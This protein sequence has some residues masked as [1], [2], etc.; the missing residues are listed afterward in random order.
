MVAPIVNARNQTHRRRPVVSGHAVALVWVMV[1]AVA[2]IGTATAQSDVQVQ[3]STDRTEVGAE[4]VI[5]YKITVSGVSPSAVETPEPPPTTNLVLKDPTPVATRDL[6]FKSG[7][8]GRSISFEWRYQPMRVGIARLRE[9]DVV[10]NGEA[11]T[12]SEIRVRIVPQSQAPAASMGAQRPSRSD[13]SVDPSAISSLKPDDL[14]IRVTSSTDRVYQNEQATVE[15]RLFFRPGVQLRHSRLA[16]AWDANGFWREELDVASRPIP[17][18]DRVNGETYRTIMLKRVAVF[19]TRTGTLQVDP[20]QIETEAYSADRV[21]ARTRF[22]SQSQYEPI[23]L[24]SSSISLNVNA[25]PAGAPPAFSGAVGQ[26]SLDANVRSDSAHVGG[27]V[28]LDVTVRGSGNIATLQPPEVEVPAAF[29]MYDPKVNT[30]LDR[31]GT[32]IRGKKTFTYIL[33]PGE[34]GRYTL[35]PVSFAYFDPEA[36]QFEVLKTDP[37]R[38]DVTGDA[39]PAALGTTGAGLPVGDIAGLMASP[40]LEEKAPL[41]LHRRAWPYAAIVIPLLIAAGLIVVRRPTAPSAPPALETANARLEE[42]R[43]RMR[44]DEDA[45]IYALLERAV[46]GFVSDRTGVSVA[47]FS[48]DRLDRFL[49]RAG[50]DREHRNGLRELLDACDQA[51]FAPS[52][53]Q[54]DAMQIAHRRA[55]TLIRHFDERL[56]DT[57]P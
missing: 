49:E 42:A 44:Q 5:T 50:A 33:V 4:D 10:I 15:Y 34:N 1:F 32:R 26:F 22:R 48:R 43:K 45:D 16:S 46:L 52:G 14:F 27:S 30:R 36:E 41:P 3:A 21:N 12:T 18:N 23:K 47:G 56:S 7:K 11:F 31:G 38:L 25:L 55:R 17:N 37:I 19:P 20:L 13:P 54:H 39:A 8:M 35:P 57:T 53:P 6:S 9:T 24:S 51:R 28:R 40:K 29:E 2:S